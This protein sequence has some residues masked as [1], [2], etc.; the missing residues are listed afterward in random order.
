M[1]R[2]SFS[3][4]LWLPLV[5]SLIALLVVSVS[6]AWLSRQT[7]I[8]ERKNDLVNVAHVGLSIVTEYALLAKS[9]ALSEADARRQALERLQHIRYG[10][11][12]YFLVIDS[13][14]RMIMHAMKP[15]LD[16]K[17]L[18]GTTD[19]DGRHHYVEFASKAQSPEGGFV[20]YVFPHPHDPSA[21]AVG[22]I[23]YVVRYAPWDWIIATG[24]YV[25]DINSAFRK[26]LYLVGGI[27]GALAV[28]LSTFCFFTNR[29]IQRAIGGDP[30]YAAQVADD[31]AAGNLDIVIRTRQGDS[32]S[33]LHTMQGMRDA[34]AR[35][36]AGIK[37]AADKVATGA[38]EIAAGNADLSARTENQA[39]SL[40]ETAA[41]MEQMTAMVRQTAENAQMA[42]Q[43]MA[44]AEEIVNQGG[45]MAGDAVSTM[46]EV[47]K[48]SQRMVEIISVIEGIAFQTN[49]LALNAAVEA[50]RAGAEGRGFAVV[51]GEVRLLAQRSASAAK[52]IRALINRTVEGI[53]SGAD[54]V[55]STGVKIRAA[56]EAIS[57]I[58]GVAS[59]IASAAAEQSAGI[60]QVN[61]AVT[62]MDS[63]TQQNA[64]L[65]EQAAAVAQ[66]LT[67][68]ATLL[69]SSISTFRLQTA[70]IEAHSSR[71]ITWNRSK[72]SPGLATPS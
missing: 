48:E 43:L 47:S 40:E 66:T 59:E 21:A 65:V 9:G 11:D 8:E 16:G 49:I 44:D 70:P 2:F 19:V 72:T 3:Q 14:P 52:E 4:K 62:Q 29:S 38:N 37:G 61:N 60:N 12:G 42:S 25:D 53:H 68:Q 20:E 10:E 18:S 54:L 51:A 45:S 5:V 58:S 1:Y 63:T 34:L 69:Q 64:A 17:D 15:A 46:H 55:D 26:S 67:E 7:R 50:A 33:L 27:F 35:T 23:G 28:L 39:A 56:Q 22:K 71:V 24:A 13:K 32:S 30:A 57:R 31:I 6:A 41:S 36:I